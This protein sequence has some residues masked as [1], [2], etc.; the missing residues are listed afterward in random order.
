MKPSTKE[1][2]PQQQ[3]LIDYLKAGHSLTQQ[4]AINALG[5]GSLTSRIAEL[6]KL[7]FAITDETHKD[8]HGASYKKYRL[9]QTTASA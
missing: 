5:I 6:R 1:L 9:E 8:F 7:G 2:S 3:M 4:I